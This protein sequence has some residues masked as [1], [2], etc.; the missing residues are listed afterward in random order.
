[1]LVWSFVNHKSMCKLKDLIRGKKY[2]K[3]LI[4]GRKDVK[5]GQQ[6]LGHSFWQPF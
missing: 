2:I 3:D 1:M 4:R 6:G 5:G